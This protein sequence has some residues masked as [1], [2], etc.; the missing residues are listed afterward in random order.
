MTKAILAQSD[1]HQAEDEPVTFEGLISWGDHYRHR[2]LLSSDVD[3]PWNGDGHPLGIGDFRCTLFAWLES[4]HWPTD[5]VIDDADPGISFLE[6]AVAFEL[7]TKSRLP[8]RSAVLGP[9]GGGPFGV[10]SEVSLVHWPR[11]AAEMSRGMAS[12]LKALGGREVLP[13]SIRWEQ[14]PSLGLCGYRIRCGRGA[15]LRP[16]PHIPNAK[17]VVQILQSV[18]VQTCR[19]K[20]LQRAVCFNLN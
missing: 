4:L 8:R 17:E 18:L 2:V 6:L 16:R 3:L 11:T 7:A 5:L 12:V 1:S 19:M 20:P 10:P 15:G 13:T 9:G 14:V